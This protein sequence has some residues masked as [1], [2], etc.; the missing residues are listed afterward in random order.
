MPSNPL[1]RFVQW[2]WGDVNYPRTEKQI[3]RDKFL[4]GSVPFNRWYLMPAAVIFQAICGSLYAW[5]VYNK[6]I[7]AACNTNNLAPVTF[8]I[9]VGCFGLSAALTGPWLERNG[10]RNGALI[11]A[12]LFFIG[13]LITAAGIQFKLIG[14]V[15]LG[16][17]VIGGSGLGLSYISP[18]SPL[19]KWFP[20]K[21][22]LASGLAVCGFGAGSIAFAKVPLPLAE[23]V[24]LP[25]TFVVLGCGFYAVMVLCALVFRVPPPNFTVNGLDVRGRRVDPMTGPIRSDRSDEEVLS[26][27]KTVINEPT[28]NLTLIESIFNRDYTLMYIMFIGNSIA[29][30]VVLARLANIASDIFG[31]SADAASTIVSINGG[32][33]LGGRLFFSTL[34]DYIGRKSCFVFML[35]AQV[36]ILGSL[37]AILETRTY[38]AFLLVIWVLTACYGAGFGIIPA[39]LTDQFGPNNIGALHGIILTA[40]AIAGV[41]GGLIF[42]AVFNG[43]LATGMYTTKSPHVYSVNFWWLFGVALIGFFFLINVRTKTSDRLLPKQP[44]ELTRLRFFGR[45]VRI[46]KPFRVELVS[47]SE[48]EAEWNAFKASY[49]DTVKMEDKEIDEEEKR[50]T[51]LEHKLELSH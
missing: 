14:L 7:D 27:D 16:Y 42:T 23:A 40:W 49:S 44:D 32:F 48:E 22:G 29:G 21:R 50:E 20:D 13:N 8:Y 18:V 15:F 24:G 12:T 3:E 37:T 38:W 46:R 47:R 35:S 36:I 19:Q 45:L 5:S 51:T 43:L 11:G 25:L 39:F 10:P 33:N 30:L 6:G 9:A 28:V 17:G 4:V 34:S 26:T 41:G 2:H 31:Q 1:L